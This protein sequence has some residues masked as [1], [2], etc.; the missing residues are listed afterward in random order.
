MK[1]SKILEGIEGFKLQGNAEEEVKEI[2]SDS[3]L[4]EHGDMFV[5]IVGYKTNGHEYLEMALEKGA[6]VV[7]IQDGEYDIDKEEVDEVTDKILKMV[8]SVNKEI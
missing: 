8:K 7:A 3:R 1:L 4:V 2:R 6:T 5:A